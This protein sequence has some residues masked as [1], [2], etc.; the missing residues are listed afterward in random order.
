MLV[1]GAVV[2][3][4]HVLRVRVVGQAAGGGG[5]SDLERGLPGGGRRVLAR[6]AGHRLHGLPSREVDSGV[7]L[8]ECCVYAI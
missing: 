1:G 7:C 2:A 4:D 3:E 8:R 6:V 5:R